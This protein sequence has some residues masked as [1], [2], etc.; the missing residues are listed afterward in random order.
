MKVKSILQLLASDDELSRLKGIEEVQREPREVF[1]EVLVD[2]L[3]H[4]PS[5][6]VREAALRNPEMLPLFLPRTKT[7]PS[8]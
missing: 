5:Q 8:P 2:L 3:Q 7:C 1:V 6:I 4:D